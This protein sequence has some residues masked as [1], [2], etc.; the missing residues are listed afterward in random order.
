MNHKTL[1]QSKAA[2]YRAYAHWVTDAEIA[3]SILSLAS[4]LEHQAM[5]PDE[6]DVRTRAYDLWRNAG[7]PEN[8]DDEFWLLAENEVCHRFKNNYGNDKKGK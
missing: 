1:L 3:Q 4:D 5:M 2:K 8:R 6:E 7:R